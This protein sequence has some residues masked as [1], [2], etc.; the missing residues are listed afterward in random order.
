MAVDTPIQI[1]DHLPPNLPKVTKTSWRDVV[2][3]LED[4]ATDEQWTRKTLLRER[5]WDGAAQYCALGY[6]RYVLSLDINEMHPRVRRA[7]TDANDGG[8]RHDA[9]IVIR[10][11]LKSGELT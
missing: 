3:W 7:I 2:E 8:G 5:M 1:P 9:A 11:Y 4:P 6:A 10:R